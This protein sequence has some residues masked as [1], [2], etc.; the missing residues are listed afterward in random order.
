METKKKAWLYC[1]TDAPEDTHGALDEH[2]EALER[3]C[4]RC[5]LEVVGCSDD[6]G[7][8]PPFDRPGVKRFQEAVK[9]GNVQVLIIPRALCISLDLEQRMRFLDQMMAMQIEVISP[10][11]GLIIEKA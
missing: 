5:N 9:K 6:I 3:Y 8:A 2:M 10:L 11:E 7:D 4:R 1:H